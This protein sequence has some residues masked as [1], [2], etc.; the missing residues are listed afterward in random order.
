MISGLFIP[1]NGTY[2]FGGMYIVGL[3]L[4]FVIGA[5]VAAARRLMGKMVN[6]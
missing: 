3:G 2:G 5:L 4:L 6:D 1:V